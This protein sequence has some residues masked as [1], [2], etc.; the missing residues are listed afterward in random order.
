MTIRLKPARIRVGLTALVAFMVCCSRQPAL[1]PP[2][3]VYT[4]RG[5]IAALPIPD[6]PASQ[7]MIRHEAV[8]MFVNSDG[9]VVGMASMEMPFT[10]ARGVSLSG[11]AVGDPVEFT[12]EVRWKPKPGSQLTRIS[13]LPPGTQV[14]VGKASGGP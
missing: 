10:P 8:P 1:P 7:L 2:D 14:H 9:K 11:L 3:Q 12:F 5:L 6:K 13:K 4:V